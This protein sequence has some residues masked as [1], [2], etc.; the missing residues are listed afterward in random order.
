MN[1]AGGLFAICF[2]AVNGWARKKCLK[3]FCSDLESFKMRL[4]HWISGKSKALLPALIL[5]LWW[6]SACAP[7]FRTKASFASGVLSDTWIAPIISADE[8]SPHP[9]H[10][11]QIVSVKPAVKFPRPAKYQIDSALYV[12]FL[13]LNRKSDSDNISASATGFICLSFAKEPDR[14]TLS[15]A[16]LWRP[17]AQRCAYL[18]NCAFLI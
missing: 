18:Q 16:D 4:P 13:G 9:K 15:P 7:G 12:L 3:V 1:R 6:L 11:R 2:P 17:F 14:I 10:D 5:I 8:F